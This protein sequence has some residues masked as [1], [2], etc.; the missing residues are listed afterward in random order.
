MPAPSPLYAMFWLYKCIV[1]IKMIHQHQ[2]WT[3]F[4]AIHNKSCELRKDTQER[5]EKAGE[6]MTRMN[7][8][9]AVMCHHNHPI[10]HLQHWRKNK[11]LALLQVD[12]IM[13]M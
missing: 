7:N 5:Q 2:L 10:Q 9:I 4:P 3:T 13:V 12:F 1:E 6:D 11:E 8:C